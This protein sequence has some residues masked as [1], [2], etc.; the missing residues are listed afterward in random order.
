[1]DDIQRV[2]F[3][4]ALEH[5]TVLFPVLALL[6]FALATLLLTR[7]GRFRLGRRMGAALCVALVLPCAFAF[8]FTRTVRG[9]LVHRVSDFSFRLVADDS[10]H[11]L[12]EYAGRVVVLNF[13]ATWCQPCLKELPELE[14]LAETRRG[15]VVVLTVSDETL[16]ELRAAVP[17][18]TARLNGY[19]VDAAPEDTIG[20]MAYQGRPTTLVIGRDGRVRETLVG[21]HSLGD[22]EAAVRR[23]L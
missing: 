4:F 9:A 14:R 12:S 16:E 3:A 6:L 2:V 7:R 23:A 22:F 18:Q 13:W 1:V 19:F 10:A 20:K 8:H 11:R 21:A 5:G 17:R 15:D